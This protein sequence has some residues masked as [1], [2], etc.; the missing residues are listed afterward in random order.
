MKYCIRKKKTPACCR[1]DRLVIEVWISTAR[2]RK[3]PFS[4]ESKRSKQSQQVQV[5]EQLSGTFLNYK[6]DEIWISIQI[7]VTHSLLNSSLIRY[8]SASTVGKN[9]HCHIFIHSSRFSLGNYVVIISPTSPAKILICLDYFPRFSPSDQM[10]DMLAEEGLVLS[11]I[12]A[13]GIRGIQ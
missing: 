1:R 11:L 6:H 10:A 7:Y 8:L 2:G 12:G 4:F 3:A 5:F 13:A 9:L